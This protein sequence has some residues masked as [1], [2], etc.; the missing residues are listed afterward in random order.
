[1]RSTTETESKESERERDSKREN[2]EKGGKDERE[3][4]GSIWGREGRGRTPTT[5]LAGMCVV[6]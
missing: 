1:M 4:G 3:R 6:N 2:G 5:I